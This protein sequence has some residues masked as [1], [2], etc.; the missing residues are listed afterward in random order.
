MTEDVISVLCFDR[1]IPQ[2]R[3]REGRY[4]FERFTGI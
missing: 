1:E 4:L 2:P 3:P